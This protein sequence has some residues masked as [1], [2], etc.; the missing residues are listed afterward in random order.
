MRMATDLPTS[1]VAL[2]KR[3][4]DIRAYVRSIMKCRV[5][6]VF[7]HEDPLPALFEILSFPYL[8]FTRGF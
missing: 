4:T 1:I 5:E 2:L 6:A 7:S 8:A 3:D